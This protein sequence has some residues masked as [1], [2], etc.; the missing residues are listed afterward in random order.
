MAVAG[1]GHL[2]PLPDGQGVSHLPEEI[3][4]DPFHLVALGF[5]AG[6]VPVAPGTAG[7]LLAVLPAWLIAPW[8]WPLRLG[9]VG[10]LFVLGVWVCGE[11][12]KRLDAHDHPGIVWDEVVGYL[13]VCVAV[14]PGPAWLAAAFLLFRLFD[15]VKPWPINVLDRRVK[16]GFGIMLDDL[17]AGIAALALLQSGLHLL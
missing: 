4:R 10:L 12:A 8:P 1:N 3:F 11:S 13:A 5:G 17:I 7:T 2:V 14:P 9:L 6:L 16:G 15:I